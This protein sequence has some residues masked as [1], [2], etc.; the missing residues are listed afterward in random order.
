MGKWLEMSANENNPP[1]VQY[2]N[3]GAEGYSRIL[4]HATGGANPHR[5]GPGLSAVFFS[6]SAVSCLNIARTLPKQYFQAS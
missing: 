3:C 5:V 1:Q 4:A 2:V 6:I